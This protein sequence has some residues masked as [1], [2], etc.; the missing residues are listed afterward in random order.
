VIFYGLV[1]AETESVVEFFLERE[2]AEAF[3]AEGPPA[4]SRTR[5]S[6]R[7]ANRHGGSKPFSA[8]AVSTL[9]QQGPG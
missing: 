3:I 8:E 6:S 7:T 5:A 1:S 2:Q 4:T 9:R